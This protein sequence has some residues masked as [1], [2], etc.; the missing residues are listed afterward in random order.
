MQDLMNKTAEKLL[1]CDIVLPVYNGL[2]HVKDCVESVLEHTPAHLYQLWLMDDASDATTSAYLQEVAGQHAHITHVRNPENLGFLKNCNKG[3]A[4]GGE[5][6]VLLLNSD[7]I[8]TQGWLQKLIRC[9]ESDSTIASVNPLTNHASNLAIPIALGV[10]F[11]DM[12][13]YLEHHAPKTYPDVVTG[14]GFCMLLRRAALEKV[15]VFDEVYGMGYCEESDLCMRLTTQG[16]RTVVADDTYVYHKGR[17]TFTN[18]DERYTH[19]RK[20]FD[21]RWLAEYK[22]Q[23]AE[24]QAKSPLAPHR[25]MFMAHKKQLALMAYARSAYRH[26]R[27]H[28]QQHNYWGFMKAGVKLTLMLPT[29]YR[30]VP[31]PEEITKL[32]EPGRLRVTYVLPTLSVAGG[33]LSVVQ[34]VNELTLLGVEARIVSAHSHPEMPDW[35][36]LTRPAVYNGFEELVRK[37]PET[38]III[39]THH[40]TAEFVHQALKR[41]KAKHG[42]YFLQDYEAWFYPESD[43]KTRREVIGSYALFDHRIVKSD[44]LSGMVKKDGYD[45]RKIRLGMDLGVFYPR[46]Q[47]KSAKPVVMAMARPSTPRRGY[48]HVVEA[49][50]QVYA[51]RPDTEFVFFGDE[52]D[53]KSLPFPCTSLGPVT[54]QRA[55]AEL[56]SRADIFLDGSTFQGFGRPALE[57][58]ACQTACVLTKVGG[59]NEYARDGENCLLVEP[60]APKAFS[61]AI[62]KLLDDRKLRA[63]LAENGLR[64]VQDYCHKREAR[65]TLT[66]FEE[67]IGQQQQLK[68]KAA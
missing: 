12:N 67:I 57:A 48:E 52:I 58:M 1:T 11:R 7:V 23:F 32:T 21:E 51:L 41:G 66:Y 40:K 42:A 9:A 43:T 29:A 34:L 35:K 55:L 30:E 2:S 22:R 39:A 49:F 44:W 28:V 54:S 59:V 24:F 50:R 18:R 26:L 46:E 38:D 14:V 36:W 19:N 16:W 64:T 15:G 3:M 62:V 56:Y 63:W 65:E 5:P 45:T 25:R 31:V 6:Y 53:T 4:L 10:S 13:W 20:I 61:D 60:E 47:A 17:A 68:K 37:M 8:V 27:H 33:V